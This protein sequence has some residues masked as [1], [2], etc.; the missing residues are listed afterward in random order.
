MALEN[1]TVLPC[2]RDPLE[3]V[4]AALAGRSDPHVDDCSYCRKA[5]ADERGQHSIA[6]DLRDSATSAPTTLLPSVMSTVWAELRPGRQVP[7]SSIGTAFATELALSSAVQHDLDLLPDLEIQVCRARLQDRDEA[8]VEPPV[9]GPLLHVDVT[10][11][12]AYP[13]DLLALADAVRARAAKTLT[14]QFG[15]SAVAI[16][17]D[18]VD[19]YE[20][21]ETL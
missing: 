5:I 13:A 10:A 4:D 2:G 3:I 18:I 16:D 19:L 12:A 8:P 11:A 7:L 9:D 14:V 20:S 6:D 17:V 15:L 1:R 21:A